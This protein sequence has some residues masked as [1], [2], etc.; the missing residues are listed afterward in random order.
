MVNESVLKADH[1][2][3]EVTT[4]I[5]EY[6]PQFWKFK[7]FFGCVVSDLGLIA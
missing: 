3:K 1:A 5:K 6:I 2:E 4:V 7:S